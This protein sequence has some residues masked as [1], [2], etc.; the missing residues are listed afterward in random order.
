MPEKDRLSN[1]PKEYKEAT[2]T[3]NNPVPISS[4]PGIFSSW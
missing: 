2:I 3:S 1:Q 4:N